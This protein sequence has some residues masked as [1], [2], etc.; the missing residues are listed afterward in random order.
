[1]ESGTFDMETASAAYLAAPNPCPG[2][3]SD[4][5]LPIVS[6]AFP[7]GSSSPTSTY[8]YPPTSLA[9][10]DAVL[11]L[12]QLSGSLVSPAGQ[13]YPNVDYSVAEDQLCNTSPGGGLPLAANVW[14]GE[15][16]GNVSSHL[17]F[18][19]WQRDAAHGI[20]LKSSGQQYWWGI[21]YNPGN[22]AAGGGCAT[23]CGVQINGQSATGPLGAVGTA[24]V[25]TC[26]VTLPIG[27]LSLTCAPPT[28]L[29]Q[30]VADNVT[31]S[32]DAPIEVYYRPGSPVG[33]GPGTALI[34]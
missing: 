8:L 11:F 6:D 26:S 30:I 33:G 7:Q 5:L 4:T 3:G 9:G 1:M 18:L 29:G 27:T 17:H 32:G 15:F 22:Y 2:T 20:T 25:T 13:L 10:Q 31:F 16:S 14:N 24:G 34:Q 12:H 23:A 28:V 21:L 19:V